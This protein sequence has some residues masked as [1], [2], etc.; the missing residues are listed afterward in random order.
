[1]T[2]FNRCHDAKTENLFILHEEVER[3][4]PAYIYIYI[5][6]F[7]NHLRVFIIYKNIRLFMRPQKDFFFSL[8]V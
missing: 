8:D 3:S 2:N 1:M 5:Y 4:H 6:I 7:F